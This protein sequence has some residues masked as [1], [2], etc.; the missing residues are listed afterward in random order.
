[1][2]LST[3][4]AAALL[5]LAARRSGI[6]QETEGGEVLYEV[7][8][9]TPQGDMEEEVRASNGSVAEIEPAD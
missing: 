2:R 9:R 4:P 1:M 6:E 5:A 8:V 7:Q 3:P